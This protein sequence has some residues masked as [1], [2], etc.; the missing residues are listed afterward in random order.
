MGIDMARKKGVKVGFMRL[1]VIW[2]F[3]EKVIRKLA[4][5]VKAFVV[6]EINYGQLVLEVERCAGG[7]A[8]TVG[9]PHG[10]GSVHDPECICKA[11]ME[12]AK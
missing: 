11:I 10:G 9:V 7:K 4:G 8:V 6:P 1:I 3:P 2:P 12:A 5:K